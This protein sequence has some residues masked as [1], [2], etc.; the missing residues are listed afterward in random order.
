MTFIYPSRPDVKSL[1]DVTATIGA[2]R[3]TAIVGPS[4]SGK[5]TI[6]GLL[7]RVWDLPS[8]DEKEDAEE[9]ESKNQLL[10]GGTDVKAY[11]LKWLRSQISVVRQDPVSCR[12]AF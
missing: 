4:G 10:V 9:K 5:S 7:L 1:D 2:G 12:S 3:V 8:S 11:N 6:A